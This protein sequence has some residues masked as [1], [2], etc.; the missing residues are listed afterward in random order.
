MTTD[1]STAQRA[2]SLEDCRIVELRDY[3][4]H[5]GQREGLVELFEREFVETQEAVGMRVMGTFTDLDRADRFVWLRG[6]ADPVARKAGLESFYDGPVWAAHRD[7]ANATM[8]DA[9]DV[10]LLRYAR[11]TWALVTPALP[12]PRASVRLVVSATVFHIDVCTLRAPVDAAWRRWFE[13]EAL[14]LLVDAGAT[15]CAVFETET[16]ENDFPRL[17]VRRGEHVFAWMSR[18]ADGA[19]AARATERLV[20]SPRWNDAVLPR[21]LQASAAPMQLLRL[22]PT[23]RSL[24]R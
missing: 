7:A 9:S 15:P 20:G 5:P 3:R 24:L 11:P 14:P 8:I 1:T 12:R 10:R 4:L 21:L 23:S 17:P 16:M 22:R 19:A 18:H 6:F 2:P 13:R